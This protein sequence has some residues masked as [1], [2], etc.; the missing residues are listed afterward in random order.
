MVIGEP[1]Y[2]YLALRYQ[3]KDQAKQ[4]L[5]LLSRAINWFSVLYLTWL[6]SLQL[7]LNIRPDIHFQ[8]RLNIWLG[9]PLICIN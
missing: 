5:Y 6:Q 1:R 4:S 3:Q 8:R 7:W 9:S 2:Q